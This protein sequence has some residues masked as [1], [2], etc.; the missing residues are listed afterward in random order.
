[1][2]VLE[3]LWYGN[4]RPVETYIEGNAEYKCLL[5]LVSGNKES[6]ENELNAKQLELFEKYNASANE[7]NAVSETAA[8]RC[9]FTL[10]MALL[11][12]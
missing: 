6:L 7:I 9:G 2:T 10:A 8:F 12:E 4:I 11:T 5:R 1:M 3:D